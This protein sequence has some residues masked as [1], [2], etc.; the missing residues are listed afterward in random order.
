[1]KKL[2]ISILSIILLFSAKTT[3]AQENEMKNFR[4]GLKIQPSI[5]WFKPDDAL[6]FESNGAKMK[7][8]YGLMTEFRLSSIICFSTGVEINSTGGGLTYKNTTWSTYDSIP[9]DTNKFSVDQRTYKANYVEIPITLKMKTPE[10]GT[11]TYFGQ[12]GVNAS[13]RW[14]GK[15]VDKGKGIDPNDVKRELD[16]T[17]ELGF[18]QLGLNVGGGFEMNLAG[19]TSLTVSINYHNGFTNV[20]RSESKNLWEKAA[21]TT[22]APNPVASPVKQNAKSKSLSLTI[23]VLF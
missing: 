17:K 11:M 12:F 20:L 22:S 14:N 16:G 1:M 7:F 9:P 13:I 19:T 5:A 15:T 21:V 4:F 18:L 10:I 6:K 3:F 23:G 8:G 2:S